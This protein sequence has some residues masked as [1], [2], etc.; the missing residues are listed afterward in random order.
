MTTQDYTTKFV[1][2]SAL[3]QKSGLEVAKTLYSLM[4]IFGAPYILQSDKGKEFR[5]QVVTGLKTLWP[6]INIIH[7]RPRRPQ[8]QGSVERANGDVQNI[9]GSLMGH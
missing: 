2:L 7:G 6:E 9:F 5:N 8:S 4:W 1:W 3:K